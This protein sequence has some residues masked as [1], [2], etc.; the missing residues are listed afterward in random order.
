MAKLA[1]LGL[2]VCDAEIVLEAKELENRRAA[3]D[4]LLES[5]SKQVGGQRGLLASTT[6]SSEPRYYSK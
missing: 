3:Y 5:L 2:D 4:R 6:T 1:T